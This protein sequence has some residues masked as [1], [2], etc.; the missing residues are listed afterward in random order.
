MSCGGTRPAAAYSRF[1]EKS[2]TQVKDSGIAR[3]L[4][5][6]A[7]AT[8][9]KP[10][11]AFSALV[12]SA[13]LGSCAPAQSVL[14]QIVTLGELRVLTRNAPTTFYYGANERHGIEYELA[15]A[16][17]DHLG[18]RLRLTTADHFW[19]ILPQ[20]A[21]RQ[22]HIAAAGLAITEPRRELVGFGPGYQDVRA[23]LIYRM[24][25]SRPATLA[26]V[27]GERL[28]VRS[29]TS[30]VAMLYRELDALPELSWAENRSSTA[31]ALVRRVADGTIDYAV[32]HSNEFEV[33][34][35]Y[36]PEVRVAF[37]LAADGELGWAL[38]KGADDLREAVNE[39]FAEMRSTGELDRILDR[40]YESAWDFDFVD[41]RAFRRHLYDRFPQYQETFLQAE[42]ETGIDWRLLAAIAYQ[43]SHWDA[44]AV[45][46][47][48]VKG[49]MM[50]TSRTANMMGVADRLDPHESILGGAHYLARVLDKFPERIPED[51][52][53]LM[54]IA[55]Y[56]TG[57]GHIEDAR[58]ITESL[59]A[60]KDSW[61]AVR[62]HLPLLSD[63]SWYPHLKRGYAQGS[64]PVQYVDSIQYYYWLLRQATGTEIFAV[65]AEQPVAA[66]IL[67]SI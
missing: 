37:D 64:I 60:D 6:Q 67:D 20:V 66:P 48:G 42:R 33:L 23:Q 41:L 44:G 16:F 30:H 9:S 40:Y 32:V 55:A 51:D 50:L 2:A 49:L 24:G 61:D 17:A 58:I 3:I 5:A 4:V 14:E 13:L 36:Y 10:L 63:E 62:T 21:D 11:R 34:R 38:P 65:L 47:T 39:F 29:G 1:L 43:E 56:N 45:S 15:Q 18:V 12:L 31:E 19:E 7:A 54:A 35:H 46:P 57:F 59:D 53:L 22:V 25:I 28:E 52:R 27:V 26:D 8:I